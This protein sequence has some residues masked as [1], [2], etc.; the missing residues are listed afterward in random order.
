[1]TSSNMEITSTNHKILD[2]NQYYMIGGGNLH[3]NI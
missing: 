2:K 1:M 3:S